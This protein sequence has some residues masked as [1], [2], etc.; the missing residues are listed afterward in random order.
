MF[1]QKLTS[2]GDIKPFMVMNTRQLVSLIFDLICGVMGV[3][4]LYDDRIRMLIYYNK[5]KSR[6]WTIT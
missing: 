2:C 1:I 5:V 3:P 4:G 6:D